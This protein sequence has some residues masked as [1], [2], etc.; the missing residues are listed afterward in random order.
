MGAACSAQ[1]SQM[2]TTEVNAQSSPLDTKKDSSDQPSETPNGCGSRLPLAPAAAAELHGSGATLQ[3]ADTSKT[4]ALHGAGY[5]G[6]NGIYWMCGT[7]NGAPRY[8]HGLRKMWIQQNQAGSHWMV[9]IKDAKDPSLVFY[10]AP[11]GM[12]VFCP[13]D[14]EWVV[15]EDW[16]EDRAAADECS[17][18]FDLVGERSPAPTGSGGK[19]HSSRADSSRSLSPCTVS[20]SPRPSCTASHAAS[21][22]LIEQDVNAPLQDITEEESS[23]L[24]NASQEPSQERV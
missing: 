3:T 13:P 17:G 21:N 15:S 7:M 1:S 24:L 6:C 8:K 4:F 23:V 12:H 11:V 19:R 20:C 2:K 9:V 5:T 16:S 10:A 22:Q 18:R 14:M